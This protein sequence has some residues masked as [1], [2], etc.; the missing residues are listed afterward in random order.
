MPKS[1]KYIFGPVPSRRL[2]LSLGIDL[3]GDKICSMDCVYCEVGKT[4]LLTLE[5]A[6]YVPAET[7]LDELRSYLEN[8]KD[9]KP[10]YI[11]FSGMGEPTLHSRIGYI[12]DKIHEMTDIPVCV[13]TNSTTIVND[14][15]FNELLKADVVIPSLD[16]VSRSTFLKINKPVK[17]IN[18]EIIIK[19]LAEFKLKFKGK[20]LIEILFVKDLND[21]DN[22]LKALSEAINII[23]PDGLQI[24]TVARP[25][26]SDMLNRASDEFLNK[27]K[28]F[29]RLS[30]PEIQIYSKNSAM[31]HKSE[32]DMIVSLLKIRSCFFE[33]IVRSTGIT[34]E[35]LKVLLN[36]L[37]HAGRITKVKFNDRI[38]FKVNFS[39]K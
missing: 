28:M 26:L 29:L 7:V 2:G 35:R 3:L 22:E 38:Y 30:S 34:S 32:D 21:N 17:N 8:L 6:E 24:H 11:T 27:A 1:Y 37:D 13:L 31:D 12:I 23:N 10:N 20:L 36:D 4:R 25:S 18:I 9:Q 15:V 14:D 16:A 33:E 5:R 19:R 39:C